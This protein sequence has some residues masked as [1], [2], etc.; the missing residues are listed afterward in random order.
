MDDESDAVTVDD[1]LPAFRATNSDTNHT[2]IPDN[3]SRDG[4]KFWKGS[5]IDLA[6]LRD[7]FSD[8]GDAAEWFQIH[9]TPEMKVYSVHRYIGEGDTC[10]YMGISGWFAQDRNT[11]CDELLSLF[12]DLSAW[13]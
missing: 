8:S 13:N 4:P 5:G 1:G 3:T 6:I 9:P 2:G 10:R 12:L 7:G 11:A